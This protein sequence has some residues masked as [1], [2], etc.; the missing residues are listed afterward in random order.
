L[1]GE[2]IAE[3]V[4]QSYAEDAVHEKRRKK[5]DL[6]EATQKGLQGEP[7]EPDNSDHEEKSKDNE[8]SH[9]SKGDKDRGA[10]SKENGISSNKSRKRKRDEEDEE[11]TP[12]LTKRP[13]TDSNLSRSTNTNTNKSPP[14]KKNVIKDEEK[15]TVDLSVDDSVVEEKSAKDSVVFTSN[16][17]NT[18]DNQFHEKITF[19]VD[20][21]VTSTNNNNTNENSN[22]EQMQV[23]VEEESESEEEPI[24]PIEIDHKELARFKVVLLNKTAGMTVDQLHSVFVALQNCAYE[25]RFN[26][27]RTVLISTMKKALS[28]FV[29]KSDSDLGKK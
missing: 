29:P 10:K 14:S 7:A 25:E 3:D 4:L 9:K 11:N 17:N 19:S 26:H 13:R 15:S 24:Q 16:N 1:K 21:D 28:Q 5:K 12:K 8:R 6:L 23:V 20:P 27:Q 18:N 2:T 22:V